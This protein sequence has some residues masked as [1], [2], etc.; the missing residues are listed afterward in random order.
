MGKLLTPQIAERQREICRNLY[1][2]FGSTKVYEYS[3]KLGLTY[4]ECKPCEAETPTISDKNKEHTCAI[5]GTNK[6]VE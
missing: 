5:C 4:H 1:S 6:L 2:D 3:N